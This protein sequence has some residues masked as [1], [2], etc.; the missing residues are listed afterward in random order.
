MGSATREISASN[1]PAVTNATPSS[2][3]LRNEIENTRAEISDTVNAIQAKL[4][5]ASLTDAAGQ[6]T[7]QAVDKV[8]AAALEVTDHIKHDI[9]RATIGKVEKMANN[10]R[11]GSQNAG[12]SIVNT[13]RE[14]PIPAALIGFGLAWLFFGKVNGNTTN[15]S[16]G[17]E[18]ARYAYNRGSRYERDPY[19]YQGRY[20]DDDVQ[21]S[22][23]GV[24]ERASHVVNDVAG[25][26]SDAA[27][28]VKDKAG[29]FVNS[30]QE[31]V[32]DVG[33]QI[34]GSAGQ[35]VNK[36][37][38]LMQENPLMAG[39]VALALGAA[40]GM[41][42]PV[43][44]QENQLM[45]EARDKFMDRAGGMVHET[46]DKAQR[47]VSQAADAAKESVKQGMQSEE[48]GNALQTP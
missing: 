18:D 42:L 23:P 16:D 40:V 3:A 30:A 48:S 47:V 34:K 28:N 1:Q 45:G 31:R 4:S 20:E 41:M 10:M 2:Y 37:Q 17:R 46:L 35:V 15:T 8:K 19:R 43:T 7:D 21:E 14:N 9:H 22:R 44:E 24:R 6:I 11:A 36:S 27:N 38:T 29:E 33:S 39:A 26:V 25:G 13:V 5:P 32:G 12:N